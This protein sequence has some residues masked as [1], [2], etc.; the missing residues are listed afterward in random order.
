[1]EENLQKAQEKLQEMNEIDAMRIEE[2]NVNKMDMEEMKQTILK[3]EQENLYKDTL[4]QDLRMEVEELEVFS[5]EIIF[6]LE[7]K[8]KEYNTLDETLQELTKQHLMNTEQLA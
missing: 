3:Y 4:C 5:E 2:L 7:K 8:A 1:M 6:N